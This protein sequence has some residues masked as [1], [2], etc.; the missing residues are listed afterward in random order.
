MRFLYD[1]FGVSCCERGLFVSVDK[2]FRMEIDPKRHRLLE[3]CE[4]RLT[5]QELDRIIDGG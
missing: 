2:W 1:G 5:A 4:M 3:I